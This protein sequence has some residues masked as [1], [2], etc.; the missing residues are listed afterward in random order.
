[1]S[2]A[3][4]TRSLRWMAASCVL[5]IGFYIGLSIRDSNDAEVQESKRIEILI[6]ERLTKEKQK[7]EDTRL[8]E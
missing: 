4:S 8:N 3:F 2:G 1:M 7:R 6:Q 5:P